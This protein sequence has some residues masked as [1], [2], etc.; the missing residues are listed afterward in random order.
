M[1]SD[2]TTPQTYSTKTLSQTVSNAHNPN[3]PNSLKPTP[4]QKMKYK[5]VNK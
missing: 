1:I 2:L 5:E 3:P 4:Q